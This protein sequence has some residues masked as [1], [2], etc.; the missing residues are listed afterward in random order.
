MCAR[1]KVCLLVTTLSCSEMGERS[2]FW[3]QRHTCLIFT[4]QHETHRI[5]RIEIPIGSP[6]R[7]RIEFSNPWIV[8]ILDFA[9][10][11][12]LKS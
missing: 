7:Y 4:V 11:E 1:N 9:N 8:G 2:W 10:S 3:F 12:T 5:K 6:V